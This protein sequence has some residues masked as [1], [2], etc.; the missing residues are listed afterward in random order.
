[1]IPVKV[2]EL[3]A[4][5]KYT[6]SSFFESNGLSCFTCNTCTVECPIFFTGSL[7]PKKIVRMANFG[8]KDELLQSKDIWFCLQCQKCSNI[9]PQKVEP[10]NVILFLRYQAVKEGYVTPAFVKLLE[11]IEDHVQKARYGLYRT[12]IEKRGE[13][14]K[15]DLAQVIRESITDSSFDDIGVEEEKEID[16]KG[17]MPFSG[18]GA[19]FTQCWTCRDCS[20]SCVVSKHIQSFDPAKIIRMYWLGMEEELLSGIELWLCISCETCSTV[21]PQGIEGFQLINHLKRMAISNN[22]Q[23]PSILNDV[24]NIEKEVHLLRHQLIDLALEQK[25]R[26]ESLDLSTLLKSIASILPGQNVGKTV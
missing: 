12:L 25:E 19:Q 21:C 20:S 26:A 2:E 24:K 6:V 15:L 8:M 7:D 13:T 11:D 4:D 17:Q 18:T 9:C 3:H 10:A 23:A 1:M 16:F 5:F 22:F 14:P